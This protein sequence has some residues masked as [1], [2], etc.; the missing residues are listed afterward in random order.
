MTSNDVKYIENYINRHDVRR[1]LRY[2][3]TCEHRSKRMSFDT[4]MVY[5]FHCHGPI[6][7]RTDSEKEAQELIDVCLE[8]SK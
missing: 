4:V 1:A 6:I 2:T 8:I 7:G 5:V 3:F